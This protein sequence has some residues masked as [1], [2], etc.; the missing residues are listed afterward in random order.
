MRSEGAFWWSVQDSVNVHCYY[1]KG[2][3]Y[4]L[5]FSYSAAQISTVASLEQFK[6]I[7]KETKIFLFQYVGVVEVT[8]CFSISGNYIKNS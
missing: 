7:N 1:W 3:S 6:G 2:Q 8:E 4:S 5:L